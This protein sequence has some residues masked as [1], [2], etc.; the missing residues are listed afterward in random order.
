MCD[1][2]DDYFKDLEIELDQ[3]ELKDLGWNKRKWNI[4]TW[5]FEELVFVFLIS[6]GA[7]L[8][9]SFSDELQHG[10]II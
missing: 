8:F 9:F 2:L 10:G 3:K 6:S 4:K 1:D 7:Y 5:T